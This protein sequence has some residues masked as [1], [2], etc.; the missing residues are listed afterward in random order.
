[1]EFRILG[2]LEVAD[3]GRVL[4]LGGA[5]Q[6]ALLAILLIRRGE[7]VPADRLIEDL[8]GVQPP[9]T[10]AKSLQVHVSRLRKALGP[11]GQLRT[12]G[13]GY[14][15]EGDLDLDRF[16]LLLAAGRR[17]L[18]NG[19]PKAAAGAFIEGLALWRGPPLVD[20]GYEQFAQ[21]EITR[22][23]ELRTSCIEERIEAELALGRHGHIVGELEQLVAVHPLRERLRAQLMLALYRSGRQAEA[24]E[25]YQEGRRLLL[26]ELGLEPGKSLRELETAVLQQDPSLDFVPTREQVPASGFVGR[27]AE[28]GELMGGLE[29]ALRGRGRLFLL[30]GEPGIGKSRLAEELMRR[31]RAR[32]AE[33]LV[34]RCWEA[35]GAPAFWPWVQLLRGYIRTTD[36]ESLRPQLGTGAAEIAQILPE[37]RDLLPGLPEPAALDSEAARFRLFDATA[38]FVRR[39]SADQPLVLVLDDLHAADTPSLLLLQF[40]ARELGAAHVLILGA[41]R[42]VDPIPAQH[43]TALLAELVREPVTRRLSLSGLGEP[44]IAHYVELVASEI[45]S[46]ELAAALH[47]GT[48]GNPLFVSETVRLLSVQGVTSEQSGEVRL[49]VSQSVRDVIGRRLAHLPAE[50]NRILVLASALGREFGL[51]ALAH[52]ADIGEQE[53]L[54]VLEEAMAARVVSDVPGAR[55]RLRFSHVLI[56][57]TLYEG[58]T[59]AGRVRSHRLAVDALESLYGEDPGQH[60]T[61]LAH[62]AIAGSDFVKGLRYARRAGDRARTLLAYEEAARLYRL[63]LDAFDLGHVRDERQRCELLLSLGEAESAGDRLAAKQAFLDAAGIARDLG[64][65]RELARA[66]AGYGGRVFSL[67]ARAGDDDQLVPLLEAGLAALDEHDVELRA[68]LLARLA[69]ALRDEHSRERRDA[70]SKEA[71]AVAR[72]SQNPGA[73]AYALDG[74]AC[75]I[76]G[77][78]TVDECFELGTEL[79]DVAKELRDDER[80]VAGHWNRFIAQVVACKVREAEVDRAAVRRIAHGLRL[81]AELFQVCAADAMLALAAGRFIEAEELV[82]EAFAYGERA[83]P[84]MAVPVHVMQRFTLADF[85]GRLDEVESSIRDLVVAHPARPAFRCALAHLH[86]QLGRRAE[87]GRQLAELGQ[88]DFAA[89]PFDQ[90]WLYGMSLLAETCVVLDDA[91]AGAVL[92]GLMLPWAA[93]NVADHPEGIRGSV[94]RYLGM[95]ATTTKRWSEASEHFEDALAMNATMGARPWL[96]HTQNDYARMLLARAAP[97]DEEK[98]RLLLA[99]ALETYRELGMQT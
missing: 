15:L 95:L 35:G 51:D 80:L 41:F 85:R 49:E 9:A 37:L 28:L 11:A 18:A 3:D 67:W 83:Q 42:D 39:A 78:D 90:E 20:V 7:V 64:L 27:E 16:E 13:G 84:E 5:R 96:A 98:A 46:P 26:D 8:Y 45:A 71:V 21:T 94:S 93:L 33:V 69:G 29:D 1:M 50:C 12:R 79:R 43:L 4:D 44:D 81:P 97:G 32:G 54:D 56:R 36:P 72:R 87:A 58:L 86:A 22:L 38:E 99:Q 31:A 70:L 61:E 2:P 47:G 40:L 6:R 76:I 30:V 75:A 10:A 24:L 65:P 52:M 19:D 92:Y 48:E 63:A 89:L 14:V 68:R 59:T 55:G 62:H 60:L 23:E 77:P 74:R 91:E 34:G 57:D 66:A 53:L 73:L 82:S 17:A 88:D 25:A